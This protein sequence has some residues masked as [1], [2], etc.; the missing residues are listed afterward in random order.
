[1]E[2]QPILTQRLIIRPPK[3]EDAEDMLQYGKE[4]E[5]A[6]YMPWKP[7]RDLDD[8]FAYLARLLE[9]RQKGTAETYVLEH[10][11][12]QQV[13]GI[14]IIKLLNPI[15]TE[16]G[17]GLSKAYWRQGYGTEVAQALLEAS[18]AKPEVIRVEAVCATENVGSYKIM[19]AIG[20][21]REAHF[22]KYYQS[23]NLN[24]R[25]LDAYVYARIRE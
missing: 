14:G 3:W 2:T 21:Q 15:H 5:V 25:V 24:G 8:A 6:Y 11:E 1:M 22:R 13:I 17:Y 7:F 20:M 23:P 9:F 16:I 4:P 18:F 12:R 10:K 19:E